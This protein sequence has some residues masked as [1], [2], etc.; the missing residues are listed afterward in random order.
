[1][2]DSSPTLASVWLLDS[3]A[4]DHFSFLR[5]W[6][7]TYT[8]YDTPC[9][10]DVTN[11][12]QMP[13]LGFRDVP[14][15]VRIGDTWCEV[16]FSNVLHTP[17]LS[18]NLLSIKHLAHLGLSSCFGPDGHVVITDSLGVVRL[19][20]AAKGHFFQLVSRTAVPLSA[21]AIAPSLATTKLW[22][23]HLGHIGQRTCI[24]CVACQLVLTSQPLLPLNPVAQASSASGTSAQTDSHRCLWSSPYSHS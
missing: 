2:P 3:A 5:D 9:F 15:S 8:L 1:M 13:C 19:Q 16:N 22:H 21:H 7:G 20:G 10:V 18:V 11:D 4:S 17:A 12:A 14:V 6:F 23:E 24:V